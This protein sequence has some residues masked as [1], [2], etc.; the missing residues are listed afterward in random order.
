MLMTTSTAKAKII[1]AVELED[2]L[3][4]LHEE[5]ELPRWAYNTNEWISYCKER[6]T[7][8]NALAKM[9]DSEYFKND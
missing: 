8:V 9:V 2:R 3:S 6:N 7:L 5:H 1:E 4:R